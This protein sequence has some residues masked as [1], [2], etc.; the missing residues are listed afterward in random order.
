M[1]SKC[2][3]SNFDGNEFTLFTLISHVNEIG[4]MWKCDIRC[5][6]FD[7]CALKFQHYLS[8][9]QNKNDIGQYKKL[10]HKCN[11]IHTK[12]TCLAT[13]IMLA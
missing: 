5:L 3:V 10:C 7:Y 1:S 11:L 6:K 4:R 12:S 9:A 13:K 2:F 8:N